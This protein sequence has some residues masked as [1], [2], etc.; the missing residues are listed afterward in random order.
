[1]G[2]KAFA[3]AQR[4]DD[5]CSAL[6]TPRMDGST[7]AY[8]RSWCH[9]KLAV[10]FANV[11]TPIEAPE[12]PSY[13]DIDIIVA[14]PL[15]ESPIDVSTVNGKSTVDLRQLNTV[16]MT[17]LNAKACIVNNGNPTIHFAIPFPIEESL[18]FGGYNRTQVGS[19]ILETYIQVDVHFCETEKEFTWELFHAA[20]GDMWNILGTT[21]RRFGLTVNNYGLYVRIPEIE[22]IDRKKSMVFLT[23]EPQRV[24]KFLGLDE[25]T[26]WARFGTLEEMFMYAAGCRMFYVKEVVNDVEG[27]GREDTQDKSAIEGQEGG[28]KGKKQL[29]HNDRQRMATRPIFRQWIEEFIPKCQREGRNGDLRISRAGIRAEALEQ[30]GVKA[31]YEQRLLEFTLSKHKDELWRGVI[32]GTVPTEGVDPAFRAAAVRMLKLIIMEGELFEGVM[33]EAAMTDE[34]GFYELDLVR[35]FVE[36]H[37]KRVG[38]IGWERQQRKA[39]E[40]MK[41]KVEKRKR[42]E[43]LEQLG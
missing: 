6:P 7:Y 23:N 34:N 25:R 30:F 42:Q 39:A 8:A 18:D 26:W 10:L 28:E 38:E 31:E 5:H 32:K 37:W 36:D 21:I 12:K 9:R 43:E 41:L 3:A 15:L 40:S 17:A 1:M 4:L 20:H 27:E 24:L 2:G 29:K 22:L 13:G 11:G 14:G 33:P 35:R 19:D 16:L